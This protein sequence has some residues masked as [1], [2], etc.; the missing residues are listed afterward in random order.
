MSQDGPET[1]EPI[2]PEA[3]TVSDDYSYDMAHDAAMEPTHHHPSG[4]ASHTAADV[5]PPSPDGDYSYDLAH[6]VPPSRR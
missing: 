3:E 5:P 4:K 1:R 6:E 2:G